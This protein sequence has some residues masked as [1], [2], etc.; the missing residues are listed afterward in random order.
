MNECPTCGDRFDRL[1][2]HFAL[3][4]CDP[5]ELSDRQR[6]IID[7]LILRGANVRSETQNP[8][9]EV[10]ATSEGWIA[11]VA[12]ALG[13]VANSPRVHQPAT[14]VADRLSSRYDRYDVEAS[15]CSDVWAFTTVPH[16]SFDYDAATGVE[17][18]R[19]LTLRLLVSAVG[20]WVGLLF[21][22]LHIDV[23]GWD[24]SGEQLRKLLERKEISTAE[25]DGDGY[26][27]DSP[28]CRYHYD[29]DVVVVPHYDALELLESVG[30]SL[31]DVAEPISFQN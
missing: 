21:G 5:P 9:L 15:A 7:F 19:P 8:R 24:V 20:T 1:G 10:Y 31:S 4:D 17:Q 2:Q 11:D 6:G 28:T 23:R 26:A 30:L 29:D 16:P 12:D 25:Y 3:G 27:E 13:W 18:L 14:D 22:S